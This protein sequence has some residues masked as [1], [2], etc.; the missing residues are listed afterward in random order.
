[1]FNDS[2]LWNITNNF[3]SIQK[4]LKNKVQEARSDLQ[5]KEQL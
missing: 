2:L 1:M 4:E 5:Q 3:N